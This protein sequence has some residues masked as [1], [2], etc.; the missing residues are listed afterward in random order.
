MTDREMDTPICLIPLYAPIRR[1]KMCGLDGH[2]MV[3]RPHLTTISGTMVTVVA[4]SSRNNTHTIPSLINEEL[5]GNSLLLSDFETSLC[6]H[7]P[8]ALHSSNDYKSVF[9]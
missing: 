1:V 7:A 6:N 2:S 4:L 8:I 3:F 9:G 5:N